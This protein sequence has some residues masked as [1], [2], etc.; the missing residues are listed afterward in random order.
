MIVTI[1]II[2]INILESFH[3]KKFGLRRDLMSGRRANRLHHRASIFHLELTH[4]Y[5]LFS[6]TSPSSQTLTIIILI[7]INPLVLKSH[8]YQYI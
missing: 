3:V 7:K 8:Y 2:I 4:I 6:L 1:I 5:I